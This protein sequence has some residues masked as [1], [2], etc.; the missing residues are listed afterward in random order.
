MTARW[1]TVAVKTFKGDTTQKITNKNIAI[2]PPSKGALKPEFKLGTPHKPMFL[3]NFL[4]KQ[5]Q[6]TADLLSQQTALKLTRGTPHNGL[7]L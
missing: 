6:L 2:Q 4:E 7:F 1:R 5:P 3:N